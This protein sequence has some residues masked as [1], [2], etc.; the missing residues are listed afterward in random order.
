M[1]T[2][3]SGANSFDQIRG[4]LLGG[5][6]GDALGAPVEFMTLTEI[7][8][9][10]GPAG[11]TDYAPAYGRLGAITDDTQMTLFTAEGMLRSY[12]RAK[13]RGICAIP[14]VVC[15][16][17]LR[18]LL[19][20]GMTP[21][22]PTLHVHTSG[23]LWTE[24]ILHQQR[25]P[26]NTCIAALMARDRASS[27]RAENNSKGAGGIMRVAPVAM[28]FAG[29]SDHAIE[30]FTIGK[31]TAW[32]THGHP[33]GYL[34]AG[35]FAVILHALLCDDT[36]ESGIERARAFLSAEADSAETIAA[37]DLSLALAESERNPERALARIGG[38]WV[39]E[40]ALAASV[41]CTLLAEDF[42]S[43]V[44]MAVN[45][46]GDSDTTGSLT[47]QLLGAILGEHAIPKPWLEALEAREVIAQVAN[48]LC[49]Y[50]NWKLDDS[51]DDAERVI[52]ERYP[53][54]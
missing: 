24:K 36:F 20:Q 49:E 15:H 26:G 29:Q 30:V 14:T 8:A 2:H 18:W 38:A 41:Y 35:A 46:D 32:L 11:V 3:I 10:F 23:W 17:Y 12:V 31:E 45:H 16:A 28:M 27:I 6:V 37:I 4:S 47:G 50:R 51:G 19:T 43:G 7:K 53:G 39:A 1:T 25:A 48:D 52:E 40:E 13:L 21:R 9:K 22:N 33:T 42:A 34:S 5:A 44:R 54:G